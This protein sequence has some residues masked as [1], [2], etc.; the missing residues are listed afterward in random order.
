VG[1]GSAAGRGGDT[2]TKI[3]SLCKDSGQS[4]VS[5]PCSPIHQA[6]MTTRE[7]G[8]RNRDIADDP[9]GD[10]STRPG[11]GGIEDIH[12]DDDDPEVLSM[13]AK[14]M[15]RYQ[16]RP[17]NFETVV[18]VDGVAVN[19]GFARS[20]VTPAK[21]EEISRELHEDCRK[22]VLRKRQA[23]AVAEMQRELLKLEREEAQQAQLRVLEEEHRAVDEALKA[24]KAKHIA[25]EVKNDTLEAKND[26]LAAKIVRL[27]RIHDE[28]RRRQSEVP[29]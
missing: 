10:P 28:L 27:T 24:A 21:L 5:A 13:L 6:T 17:Q 29:E 25:L 7:D 9:H 2:A 1:N 22:T 14:R 8:H 11:E 3:A 18:D 20:R 26:A 23:A 12:V 16:N 19:V 15:E 4:C